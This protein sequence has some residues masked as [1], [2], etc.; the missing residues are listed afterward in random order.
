MQTPSCAYPAN[1]QISG[2]GM[3]VTALQMNEW[4]HWVISGSRDKCVYVWD[5]HS[6][7]LVQKLE[8]HQHHVSAVQFENN[9]LVSCS[10][11]GTIKVSPSP[12]T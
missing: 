8:A 2:H 10:L 1:T 7:R 12:L 6:N 5:L 11:D 4:R 3:T 9:R